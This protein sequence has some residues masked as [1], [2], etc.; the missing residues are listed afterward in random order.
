MGFA[1]LV[2]AA[3]RAAMTLLGGELV[4]Y[5]P[6]AGALPLLL[7]APLGLQPLDVTGIF[8]SKFVLSKGDDTQ[9]G[10][11]VQVPAVFFRLD[12]LPTDPEVDDPILTI[13][14]STYRV[15]ERM[16]DGLGGI[17]LVVRRNT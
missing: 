5:T 16:P 3:D 17:V 8:D 11:E 6:G 1:E 4:T 2:E 15:I 7:P 13:R 12:D 14:G 9:A 10:V